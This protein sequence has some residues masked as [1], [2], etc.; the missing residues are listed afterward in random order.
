MQRGL[1]GGYDDEP[2]GLF[3][4]LQQGVMSPM[5]LSGAALLSGEGMN[6]AFNGMR[7]GAAFQDDKR[8]RAT[9]AREQEAYAGLL[10][11]PELRA[12]LPNGFA[13]VLRAAGPER[14]Y[15]ILAKYADPD[16]SLDVE[17]Q[18]ANLAKTQAETGKLTR[19]DPM[20]NIIAQMLGNSIGTPAPAPS[21]G[22]P[23]AIPQSMPG[24]GPRDPRLQDATFGGPEMGGGLLGGGVPTPNV[25][26]VKNVPPMRE[27]PFNAGANGMPAPGMPQRQQQPPAWLQQAQYLPVGA[28]EQGGPS[29]GQQQ[30]AP[31]QDMVQTPNGLMSRDE[32]RRLGNAMLMSPKYSAIGKEF[33]DAARDDDAPPG[34]TKPTTNA[35]QEKQFNA[36]EQLARLR[37]I[38]QSWKPE[39]Q[40]IENRLGFKWNALM[41]KF[42]PTRKSLTSQQ[43]QE[44]AAYSASRAEAIGN[45]NLYIKEITGAAMAIPEAERIK[46]AQPNPG[47]GVFDGDSPIE[48]DSKMQSNIRMTE[49]AIARYNYLTKNGFK[50]DVDAMSRT[51]PLDD[52]GKV[53]QQRTDSL[54]KES[55]STNPGLTPQDVQPIVQQRLRAEF[56]I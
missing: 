2:Q 4:Q 22:P 18:R 47:E 27:Q 5:F 49:M 38:K 9:A 55:L 40:Q 16:R 6:G 31:Q 39:Y 44:L 42:G 21:Q 41:D 36:I 7:V 15:P 32:A 14:G 56:G 1:L 8:K 54:L 10:D 43:R 29:A 51:I 48:F 12:S 17:L 46:K 23:V 28:P 3:G 25:E 24:G 53:I 26:T 52:M 35:L 50:G 20:E 19:V 30:P 13:D 37:G 11:N 45:L 34:F 33:L